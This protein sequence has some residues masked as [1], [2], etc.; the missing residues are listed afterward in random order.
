[1]LIDLSRLGVRVLVDEKLEKGQPVFLTI[2]MPL[3][4]RAFDKRSSSYHVWGVVRFVGLNMSEDG[5]VKG[6]QLGIALIGDSEP[7]G[8]FA[9]LRKRYD[10]KPFPSKEGFWQTR[11]IIQIVGGDS[12]RPPLSFLF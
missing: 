5:A 1:M 2:P 9:D 6:Y 12:N 3:A 7:P 4:L 8:Y 10:L 11:E